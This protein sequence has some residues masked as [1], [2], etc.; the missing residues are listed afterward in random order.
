MR[1][2][3]GFDHHAASHTAVAARRFD[4]ARRITGHSA[5]RTNTMPRI[6]PGRKRARTVRRRVRRPNRF[7]P[8]APVVQR[9]CNRSP[10][11]MPCDSGPPLC[12]QRSSDREYAVVA[13]AEHGD[14][15]S[16]WC[17]GSTRAPSGWMS[18]SVQTGMNFFMGELRTAACAAIAIAY[19]SR[20]PA[21]R[22]AEIDARLGRLVPRIG[23]AIERELQPFPRAR[24]RPPASSRIRSSRGRARRA[25]CNA[26]YA[27]GTSLPRDR[28]AG[29]R[30]CARA[31]LP[32]S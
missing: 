8:D 6:P 29:T 18:S 32:A 20:R 1:S 12:G 27:R 24:A 16:G 9:A 30:R 5:A 23:F 3:I 2:A 31:L 11:T 7:Q 22:I 28:V 4:F 13:G 14:V 10:N 26:R 21:A 25:R 15:P 17:A 19:T